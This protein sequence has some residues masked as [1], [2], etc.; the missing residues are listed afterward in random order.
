MTMPVGLVSY[1]MG[2]FMANMAR[3]LPAIV[4][5]LGAE[6]PSGRVA[7]DLIPSATS[8]GASLDV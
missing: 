1:R 2:R 5:P 8:S 3:S 4:P 6:G 7:N